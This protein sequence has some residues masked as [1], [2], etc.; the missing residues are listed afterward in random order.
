MNPDACQ[1]EKARQ[2]YDAPVSEQM[3]A[4]NLIKRAENM[5][6][7]EFDFEKEPFI[8]GQTLET[9]NKFSNID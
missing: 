5:M 8:D 4:I 1:D 2:F 6:C 3:L 7:L 9:R